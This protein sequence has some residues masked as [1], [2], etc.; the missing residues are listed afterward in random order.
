MQVAADVAGTLVLRG[1]LPGRARARPLDPI[2]TDDTAP[3]R[4][5]HD[6]R[7]CAPAPPLQYRAVVLD[8]AGT[9]A[10]SGPAAAPSRRRR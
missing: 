3:Y 7:R 1:H 4:V 9:P 2:G 6:V 10:A 5:F 8:N